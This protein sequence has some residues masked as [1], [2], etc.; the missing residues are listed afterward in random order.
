[1]SCALCARHCPQYSKPSIYLGHGLYR[2]LI[3]LMP[4]EAGGPEDHLSLR[5]AVHLTVVRGSAG[6]QPRPKIPGPAPH[7]PFPNIRFA[8]S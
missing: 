1:M 3:C 7:A 5:L 8:I 6:V 2:V 4:S